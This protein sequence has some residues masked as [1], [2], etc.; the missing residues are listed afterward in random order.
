MLRPL[1]DDALI[2]PLG[3]PA[4]S[5]YNRFAMNKP[6]TQHDLLAL[7]CGPKASAHPK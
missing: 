6:L 4:K 7:I 1:Q 2:A 5:L 3:M